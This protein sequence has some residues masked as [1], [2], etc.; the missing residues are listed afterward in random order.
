MLAGEKT[1]K[2]SSKT[3]NFFLKKSAENSEIRFMEVPAAMSCSAKK[4][5][6]HFKNW[7]ICSKLFHQKCIAIEQDGTFAQSLTVFLSKYAANYNHCDYSCILDPVNTRVE[8]PVS[9]VRQSSSGGV[10][11]NPP[12]PKMP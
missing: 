6:L 3:G 12:F 7:H 4:K 11:N 1:R 5:K 9:P 8:E 2:M 10:T